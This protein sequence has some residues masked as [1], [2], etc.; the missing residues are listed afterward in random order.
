MKK[1]NYIETYLTPKQVKEYTAG[2][3]IVEEMHEGGDIPHPAHHMT[4]QERRQAY[5]DSLT[6]YN[7]TKNLRKLEEEAESF[8][9]PTA[10]EKED[11]WLYDER[12]DNRAP[13]IMRNFMQAASPEQQRASGNPQYMEAIARLAK[14]NQEEPGY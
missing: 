7:W 13:G 5:G 6:L 2:G 12:L 4:M 3:Y 9:E 11:N 14:W 10:K 1:L 8:P